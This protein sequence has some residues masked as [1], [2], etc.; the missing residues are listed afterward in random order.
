MAK[1]TIEMEMTEERVQKIL[2]M[3]DELEDTLEEMRKISEQVDRMSGAL[4]DET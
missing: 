4:S 2:E 3:L 1:V